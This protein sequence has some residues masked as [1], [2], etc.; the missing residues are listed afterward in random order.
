MK[1]TYHHGLVNFLFFV[2]YLLVMFQ[3]LLRL[4]V[5]KQSEKSRSRKV[6]CLNF[7]CQGQE[8]QS[9]FGPALNSSVRNHPYFSA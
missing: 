8:K 6:L 3:T 1:M 5:Y 9:N 2:C 7:F 4:F